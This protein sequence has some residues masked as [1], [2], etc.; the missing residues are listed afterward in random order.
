MA[1]GRAVEFE[2]QVEQDLLLSRLI[3][4]IG[5]DALL[6]GELIFRGGTCFH[7]LYLPAPLRY[8]EDLDYVRRT[9]SPI[10]PIFDALRSI[11]ERVGMKVNTEITRH[12]KVYL[13]TPFEDG[14]GSP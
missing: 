9:N 5:N 3:V 11:G 1:R 8:S 10:G 2:R 7:K 13:R 12:P 14:S 4:E 6:G